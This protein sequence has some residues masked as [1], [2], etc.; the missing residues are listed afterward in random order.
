MKN[1]DEKLAYE[2]RK[3]EKKNNL[4]TKSRFDYN[5]A[6]GMFVPTRIQADFCMNTKTN[7]TEEQENAR[8]IV[9]AAYSCNEKVHH[10]YIHIINELMK[11]ENTNESK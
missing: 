5:T 10:D 7:L 11:Y 3:Q 1:P 6:G 2:Q 8:N 9:L 4:I